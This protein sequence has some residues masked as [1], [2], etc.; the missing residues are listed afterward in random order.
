MRRN[1][2]SIASLRSDDWAIFRRTLAE[3]ARGSVCAAWWRFIRALPAILI[4]MLV[5]IGGSGRALAEPPR[6]WDPGYRAT[7]VDLGGLQRLRFL[8]SLDF[9]PFN[10]ADANRKPTGFNVDLARAICAELDLVDRCEIQAMPWEE[11]EDSLEARRGEVILAGHAPDKAM[12]ARFGLSEPYFRFPARFAG[13]DTDG[14][15]GASFAE[16]LRSARVAVVANTPHA[17]M[18]DAFFPEAEPAPVEDMPAAYAA[19]REG[20]A[21]L[22]FGDGVLLSFWLASPAADNCCRFRSGP[23][24]SDVYLGQGM[25]AVTRAQDRR[26]LDAINGALKAVEDSGAYAEIYA[27]YFPVDPF[28]T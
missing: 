12:R 15:T 25:V 7:T 19:L 14:G 26:L 3:R 8:T 27:R 24:L 10:F 23:Y 4:L 13:R 20:K 9:P 5:A 16:L 22:V 1:N 28:G 21:D 2:L 18:L 17:A 6:L 11:L